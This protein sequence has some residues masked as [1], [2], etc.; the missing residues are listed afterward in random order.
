MGALFENVDAAAV[1][2]GSL[3]LI[4]TVLSM[5]GP[6]WERKFVLSH[7]AHK[8]R[9][10]SYERY[11]AHRPVRLYELV[12]HMA[13]GIS[14]AT[15]RDRYRLRA[16]RV[17]SLSHSLRVQ[18]EQDAHS[19]ITTVGAFAED[20]A[21]SRLRLRPFLATYHLGIIREGGIAVPIA[22][23]LMARGELSAEER[24]RLAWGLTLVQLAV[25]YNTMARQQRQAVY[26][27]A[28]GHVPPVGPV[29]QA[30][31]RWRALVLNPVDQL[32]LPMK[33]PRWG[34]FRWNSWLKMIDV[35]ATGRQNV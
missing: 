33:L 23:V 7:K 22:L 5:D 6:H 1:V 35:P 19:W 14:V 4:I 32:G 8:L 13:L 12:P 21:R 27:M 25:W 31:K 11:Y 17:A 24:D 20:A 3:T 2:A 16:E 9:R 26:F 10:T 28:K 15:R 29:L 34:R 18:A 30:P